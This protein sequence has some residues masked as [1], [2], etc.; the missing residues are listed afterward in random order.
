VPDL[1]FM[2]II[3][4]LFQFIKPVERLTL[5]CGSEAD[6]CPERR[7]QRSAKFVKSSA[8]QVFLLHSTS[9]QCTQASLAGRKR[10][11]DGQYK[12]V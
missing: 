12:I 4:L 6:F 5:I 7:V 1:G 2:I 9:S 3:S 11:E 10:H 8:F